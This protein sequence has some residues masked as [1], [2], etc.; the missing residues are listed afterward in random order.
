L[1]ER[2]GIDEG[3]LKQALLGWG[4]GKYDAEL[5]HDGKAVRPDGRTAATLLPPAFG[6][7]GVNTHTYTGR[8][9]VTHWNGYV[10][11]TQMRGKGTVFDPRLNDAQKFPVAAKTRDWNIRN[12]PDLVTAKLPALHYYQLSPA[13]LLA[14]GVGRWGC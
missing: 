10:A 5:L 7:A 11:N 3:Q 13:L 14:L 1:T 4:P 12:D 8:G 2:P 9:S 6:L